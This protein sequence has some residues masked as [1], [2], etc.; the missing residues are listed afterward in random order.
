M[1]D[2]LWRPGQCRLR[3]FSVLWTL[4]FLS[5]AIQLCWPLTRIFP[6]LGLSLVCFIGIIGWFRPHIMRPMYLTWMLAAW[7][8]GWLISHVVIVVLFF[9]LFM[10]LGLLIRVFG[11][12]P[13]GLRFQPETASYWTKKEVFADK[14]RY[15]QQF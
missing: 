15:M 14:H 6:V 5:L 2:T 3:Q 1:A 13:L 7:P 11:R 9:G 12:D 8:I 4:I 10:P